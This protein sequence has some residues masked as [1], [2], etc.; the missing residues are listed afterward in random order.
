MPT[1]WLDPASAHTLGNLG[2]ADGLALLRSA[3]DAAEGSRAVVS[4][5]VARVSGLLSRI[6]SVRHG[7]Q[8]AL[9]P[10]A[11]AVPEAHA[12]VLSSEVLDDSEAVWTSILPRL[13]DASEILEARRRSGLQFVQ[14]GAVASIFI[15]GGYQRVNLHV[16]TKRKLTVVI[17]RTHAEAWTTHS[18]S[19]AVRQPPALQLQHWRDLHDAASSTSSRLAT[20]SIVAPRAPS[21]TT[22]TAGSPLAGAPWITPAQLRDLG[23][24]DET[25]IEFACHATTQEEFAELIDLLPEALFLKL[26]ARFSARRERLEREDASGSF[27]EVCALD[28][29][30]RSTDEAGDLDTWLARLNADQRRV[31]TLDRPGPI[32]L[33]GGPGTGKTLVALLRAAWLLDRAEREERPLRVSVLVFDREL[34]TR[35]YDRCRGLGLDRFLDGGK[36]QTLRIDS[37]VE[38][39]M[40]VARI[41]GLEPLAAYRADRSERNR[42]ALLELAIEEAR[43]RLATSAHIALWQEFDLRSR[44]GLWEIETEVSQ[45]I[46]ARGVPSLADYLKARHPNNWWTADSSRAFRTFVWEVYQVYQETLAQLGL[47][48]GDDVVLEASAELRRPSFIATRRATELDDYLIIDEAQDLFLHQ[49]AFACGLA[50]DPSSLMLCYDET[51]AVYSRHPS[52][53]ELGT[54]ASRNFVN[55]RLQETYRSTREITTALRTLVTHYPDCE[56]HEHWGSFVSAASSASGP[57][58][59]AS[60]FETRTGMFDGVVELLASLLPQCGAANEIAVLGF[61]GELL[62]ELTQYLRARGL[63]VAR[64]GSRAGRSPRDAYVIAEPKFVKGQQ[65]SACVLVGMDRD[66]VPDMSGLANEAQRIARLHDELRRVVVAAS[67]AKRHLHF[68]WSGPAPSTFVDAMEASVERVG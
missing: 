37:L 31:V 43:K 46:K 40:R 15:P 39:A 1:F 54:D 8:L 19:R 28:S 25:V 60:G 29:R 53:R 56:A 32:R 33:R 44:H 7:W 45:F 13:V 10:S 50:R 59:Q 66:S 67:R 64:P 5:E 12:V 41:D 30:P 58:P 9:T 2:V 20:S 49:L 34:G 68:V 65:F 21:G 14:Q 23:V 36:P 55:T 6:P 48:D 27:L 22:Q 52:L 4:L 26:E 57:L 42:Y 16:D 62:D 47:I 24:E 38:R 18:G 11:V 61:S 35:I 3:V 63:R 17:Q 51:Q